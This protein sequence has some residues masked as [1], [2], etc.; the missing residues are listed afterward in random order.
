VLWLNR[1]DKFRNSPRTVSEA[2]AGRVNPITRKRYLGDG[3]EPRTVRHSNAVVR[4]FYEFWIEI[5]E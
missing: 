4:S 3:Y 2:T 1:A 5:G